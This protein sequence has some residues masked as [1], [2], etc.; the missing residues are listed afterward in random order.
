MTRLGMVGRAS[1][2]GRANT[3]KPKLPAPPPRPTAVKVQSR[4][5]EVASDDTE[6]EISEE[7]METAYTKYLQSLYIATKSFENKNKI[8]KKCDKQ[9]FQAFTATEELRQQVL[10]KQKENVLWASL[11]RLGR[12][13]KAVRCLVSPVLEVLGTTQE[14]LGRLA[15]GLSRV[16]H[17]L[18]VHGVTIADEQEAEAV[19]E[20]VCAQLEQFHTSASFYDTLVVSRAGN[21]KKMAAQFEALAESYSRSLQLIKECRKLVSDG[22]RLAIHEASVTLSLEQLNKELEKS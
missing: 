10:Q 3:T 14:D 18:I 22:E 12:S 21:I 1:A 19:L 16:Q 11:N 7:A 8:E 20:S 6:D 15:E 5:R 17:N 4:S 13:L 2:R 9:L